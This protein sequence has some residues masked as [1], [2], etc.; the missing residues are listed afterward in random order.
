MSTLERQKISDNKL[1]QINNPVV[2][3]LQLHSVF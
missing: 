3:Y 1:I 2:D